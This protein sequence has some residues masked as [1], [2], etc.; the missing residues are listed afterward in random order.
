[1]DALEPRDRTLAVANGQEAPLGT[2]NVQ[3]LVVRKAVDAVA[4]QLQPDLALDALRAGDRGERDPTLAAIA[5]AQALVS[6]AS[7]SADSSAWGESSV[8]GAASS[9]PSAGAWA[10]SPSSVASGWSATA[11]SAG[12]SSVSGSATASSS[13]A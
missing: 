11:S 1:S 3:F 8:A 2:P 12:A 6:S 9:L 13:P 10:D 7:P 5:H 4:E